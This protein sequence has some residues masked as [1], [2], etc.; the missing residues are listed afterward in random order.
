MTL[1]APLALAPG[2]C[3]VYARRLGAATSCK[4]DADANLWFWSGK[5]DACFRSV[6]ISFC[7]LQRSYARWILCYL[8]ARASLW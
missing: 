7:Q 5:L 4:R 8:T 2:V 6:S 3:N 1:A